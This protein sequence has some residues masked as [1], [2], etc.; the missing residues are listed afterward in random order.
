MSKARKFSIN[1]YGGNQQSLGEST[2]YPCTGCM[3]YDTQGII[4]ELVVRVAAN[5]VDLVK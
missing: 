1:E 4:D 5:L 2:S 3:I